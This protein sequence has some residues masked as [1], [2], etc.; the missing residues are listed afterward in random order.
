MMRKKE[1]KYKMRLR[2]QR[3]MTT[4]TMEVMRKMKPS[5]V[6]FGL[7]VTH[8]IKQLSKCIFVF[9]FVFIIT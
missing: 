8:K 5:V 7:G 4:I 1:I 6:H 3:R 2:S 9:S